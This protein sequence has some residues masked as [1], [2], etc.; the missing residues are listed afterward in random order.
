MKIQKGNY[1][2][3]HYQLRLDGFD[4]EII[5]ETDVNEPAQFIVGDGEMLESI[6]MKLV[7]LQTGD[8]F[9]FMIPAKDAFGF[10]SEDEIVPISLEEL[11]KG[12]QAQNSK[13]EEGDVITLFDEDGEEVPVEI[14]GF[15]GDNVLV[16]TNHPLADEDLYFTGVIQ[17]V[18]KVVE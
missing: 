8:D 4:G 16:D 7:G 15:E 17:L 5:E 1:V 12:P 3:L 14:V 9:K 13:F 6:E 18:E 11:K 2:E 10:Y